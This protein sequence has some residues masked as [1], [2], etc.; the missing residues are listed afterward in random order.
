MKPPVIAGG[1]LEGEFVVLEVVFAHIDMEALPA[2]IVKRPAG[3]F[4]FPGAA[5][6]ADVAALD[7]LLLD[8]GQVLLPESD[9][10]SGLDG[11]QM[12]DLV[13]HSKGQGRECLVGPFQLS[14]FVK[15]FFG[16]VGSG[17]KRVKRDGDHLVR[18]IIQGLHG[19]CA[20]LDMVAVSINQFPV[21]PVFLPLFRILHLSDLQ[22]VFSDIPLQGRL[23]NPA[24]IHGF[25]ADTGDLVFLR[26]V[27]L[28][29]DGD[30]IEFFDV[31]IPVGSLQLVGRQGAKLGRRV[32]LIKNGRRKPLS[33]QSFHGS[34]KG[35]PQL[36]KKSV[37]LRRLGKDCGGHIP[38]DSRFQTECVGGGRRKARVG[39]IESLKN[40]CGFC[41][42][43]SNK[44]VMICLKG[45]LLFL[46]LGN[47]IRT[48]G[49]HLSY[50]AHHA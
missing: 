27:L 21:D 30:G 10:E 46:G 15:I 8:L 25:L 48:A 42:D 31:S 44:A 4:Y 32:V 35:S 29:E 14:V 34:G 33:F 11:F 45:V 36:F 5:L 47:K 49:K 40:R 23:N 20:G 12:I 26:I 9:V 13:L 16:I 6:A 19:F 22:I 50:G 1:E 28:E 18:V 17:E 43:G 7:Q 37:S 41:S 38:V 24:Q 2:D 3:D 39:S